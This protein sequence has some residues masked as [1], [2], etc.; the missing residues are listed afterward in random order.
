MTTRTE[1]PSGAESSGSSASG[2]DPAG[3]RQ[4]PVRAVATLP[5]VEP[6][7]RVRPESEGTTTSA[8]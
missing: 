4:Q 8:A 7:A 6:A 1:A 5:T 2:D 3:E